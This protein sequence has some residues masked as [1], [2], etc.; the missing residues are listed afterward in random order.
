MLRQGFQQKLQ[1]K[2][3]PLQ[4][5]LMKLIQL[6]T[7]AFEQR[8]SQEIDENPALEKGKETEPID[9]YSN[10]ESYDES[11]NESIETEVNIDEYL[12]DDEIPNY[13]LQS[14]NYSADDEDTRVPYSG[15]VTFNQHLINQLNTFRLEEQ[16][17]Q[18]AEFIVG[19]ID[20]NGY[21]RRDIDDI[22]DDLAFS[23]NIFTTKKEVE[24]ILK[25]VQQLDPPGVGAQSLK[26]CLLLQLK[27]KEDNKVRNLAVA[28]LEQ[29]FDLF[30][31]KHYE[32]LMHK[33]DI[34]IDELKEVVDEIEKLNPKPGSSFS[35]NLAAVEQIV[36][37]FTIRINDGVL[38]LSLNARN[39]PD[40]HVSREYDN[41]LKGYAAAKD[42]SKTQ[43]DAVLFIKQKLDAAKWFIDAIKQRQQTLLLTMNAIMYYQQEYF[44]T[45]DETKLR[46]MVLKNIANKINMDVSTI[47]R[48]ANS[49]YVDTPY[50]TNLIKEFFSES[51][52]NEKGED[53][54][55]RE[56]KKIL[57]TEIE[58]ED[59]KRPLT[60]D[61]LA[62]LLKEKGYLIAR[63]T[64][65]KYREQLDIPVA[66][67]RKTIS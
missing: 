2:L 4:I 52:K 41:M 8:L 44:L 20:D 10:E 53:I 14:N 11:G 60:D 43:K 54:S 18:I 6:P 46:P 59:K 48:V 1:Q 65:A 22:V 57:Q 40:L 17:A 63:R 33:F 13:K 58:N 34:S 19:C 5:Q 27:R 3:S 15:G 25:I 24:H 39:A 23:E 21:I 45:G 61:K 42:K 16:E 62:A 36:P 30:V 29:S 37:D 32:K 49:K 67:L 66:R 9:E 26:E 31:K 35:G 56:I 47:S 7:Q 50:G 51:M 28:I 12:S 38:D 55:T 64:V